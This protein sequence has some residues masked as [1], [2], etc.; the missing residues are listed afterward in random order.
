MDKTLIGRKAT[1]RD[2][3]TSKVR[4]IVALADKSQ[5]G[6]DRVFVSFDG[7][8]S[9]F[10]MPMSRLELHEKPK[11]PHMRAQEYGSY[12]DAPRMTPDEATEQLAFLLMWAHSMFQLIPDDARAEVERLIAVREGPAVDGSVMTGA[13][14]AFDAWHA[15]YER[16]KADD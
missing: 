12:V 6:E 8:M 9:S 10:P 13:M 7:V 1:I 2:S 5:N 16:L 15:H 11:D 4:D 14:A 3:G